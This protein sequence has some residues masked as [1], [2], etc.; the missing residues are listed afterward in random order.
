[1]YC[2]RETFQTPRIERSKIKHASQ[3]RTREKIGLQV[4]NCFLF[5]PKGK[6]P[7]VITTAY[8]TQIP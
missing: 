1:M 4:K 2:L 6:K 5:T 7:N 8:S 3:K